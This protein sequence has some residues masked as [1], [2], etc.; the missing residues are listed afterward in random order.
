MGK[1]GTSHIVLDLAELLD[2]L[3]YVE[4]YPRQIIM[5]KRSF[6]GRNIHRLVTL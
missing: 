2:E 5:K 6:P 3:K 1:K 4:K